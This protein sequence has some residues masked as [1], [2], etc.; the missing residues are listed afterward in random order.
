MLGFLRKIIPERSPLRLAYHKVSAVLAAVFYMFPSHKLKIIAVTGTS[1]KSTTVELIHYLLQYSGKKAGSL[2]TIN[3]H[4]GDK[5]EPNTTLR[6]S[7]RPWT[8]QR[9]LRR[10]VR[11][12]LEYVVIEASSH[13]IDQNRLWGV[14]V[15]MAVLTNVSDNEHLDYHG[16]FAEYLRV[17]LKLFKSLNIFFRKAKV[18]KTAILNADD[19]QFQIFD[20]VPVDR[21]WTYSWKKSADVRALDIRLGSQKTEFNLRIP[22]HEFKVSVPLLGRHNLENLLAA[23]SVSLFFGCSIPSVQKSLEQFKGIP[24]RLEVVTEDQPFS[25]VV[26]FSYKPSAL[27]AVLKTLREIVKKRIIVIWGGAGGR[28]KENRQA[29]AE[30]LHRLA[31]EFILTTDDPLNENPKTIAKEIRA[32]VPRKEGEYFFEIEDRYEAIRYGIFVAEPGDLVLV[33]GRGHE[34]VQTIGEQE[35]PFDDREV[36]REILRNLELRT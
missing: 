29:S 7:L 15:D 25:V 22:N 33:A 24:G 6:T 14:S 31:D 1:G 8:T 12:D 5:T 17:K 35:I 23:L 34:V 4:F 10:M 2:S 19:P 32:K 28:S 26:D 27:E 30:I 13:A 21:K 18:Q 36:C 16:N 3:F 20:E 9:L 11:E